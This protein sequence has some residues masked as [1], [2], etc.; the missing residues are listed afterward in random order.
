M[1]VFWVQ[2]QLKHQK[3][4]DRVFAYVDEVSFKNESRTF[5]SFVLVP[6]IYVQL[7]PGV[8]YFHVIK[9]L[10]EAPESCA[11]VIRQLQKGGRYARC[12]VHHWE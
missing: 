11:K 4:K 1:I 12:H 6:W 7:R 3:A 9:A 10:Q 5:V 2:M 8:S